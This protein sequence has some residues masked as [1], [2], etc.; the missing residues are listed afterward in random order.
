LKL[1]PQYTWKVVLI[2]HS[3]LTTSL[4]YVGVNSSGSQLRESTPHCSNC[5]LR[6]STPQES[7]LLLCNEVGPLLKLIPNYAW[8][9]FLINHPKLTSTPPE[10]L[11][12]SHEKPQQSS[13]HCNWKMSRS[14]HWAEHQPT[15]QYAWK[16]V[17]IQPFQARDVIDIHWSQLHRESTQG[18]NSSLL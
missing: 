3:K 2:N 8:M 5:S 17:L 11:L 7:L 10:S 6:E 4:I 16:V 13:A 9:V 15:L 14:L 18:V 1:T 12:G